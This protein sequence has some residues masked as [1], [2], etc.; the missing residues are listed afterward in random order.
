MEA[1]T[2]RQHTVQ[3]VRGENWKIRVRPPP[4]KMRLQGGGA[5][6]VRMNIQGNACAHGVINL[7]ISPSSVLPDMTARS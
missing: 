6:I 5:Q 3:E 1:Q 2:I 7:D 4:E